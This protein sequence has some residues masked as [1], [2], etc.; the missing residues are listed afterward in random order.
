MSS[1]SWVNTRVLLLRSST[2]PPE[3][4]T[5][6]PDSSFNPELEALNL[7]LLSAGSHRSRSSIVMM[8][9]VVVVVVVVAVLVVEAVVKEEAK[10][11]AEVVWRI[12]RR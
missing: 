6:S 11:E 10:L 2:N 5:E 4:Q 7:P 8:V 12:F 9:A 1:G 3:T